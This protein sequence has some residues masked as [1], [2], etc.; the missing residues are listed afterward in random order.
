MKNPFFYFVMI[1]LLLPAI[2]SAEWEVK[3]L[4][5]MNTSIEGICFGRNI[6]GPSIKIYAG[7][8]WGGDGTG[9][10]WSYVDGSWIVE[11][12][13]S[14]LGVCYSPVVASLKDS[15]ESRLYIG[16][17][18]YKRLNEIYHDGQSW[19][20]TVVSGSEIEKIGCVRVAEGRNDGVKRL[21]ISHVDAGANGGLY[22]ISWD[23]GSG[24]WQRLKVYDRDVGEFAIA[25]GRNDGVY[26]IYAGARNGGDGGIVEFTWNGSDYVKNVLAFDTILQNRIQT[27]HVGDGRGDGINR[28]YVNEWGGRLI[29][30]TYENP[31]WIPLQ[32]AGN[33]SI[34]YLTTGKLHP[35]NKSRLYAAIRSYGVYEYT[36]KESTYEESVDAIS[37]ATGKI[38]IGDGRNDG[39]NRLY[40]GW[41]PTI[42]EVSYRN[43]SLCVGD[44][45]LDGFVD[46][47]DLVVLLQNFG[48]VNCNPGITCDGDFDADN[49]IDGNDLAGIVEKFDTE[50]R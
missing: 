23:K 47:S 22:E 20:K 37:G 7:S 2:V 43:P 5:D 16:G 45:D 4:G 34:F 41:G 32:V 9:Y 12:I 15:D 35:D 19:G 26:R 25:N 49:D 36:W 31:N 40:V 44:I 30:L 39:I 29:E 10:E 48:L 42:A 33:A 8:S 50:C 3:T 17:Y 46:E 13:Y 6:Q 11:Q 38:I 14:G 24:E 28:V 1:M 27:T 18:S 21:Y